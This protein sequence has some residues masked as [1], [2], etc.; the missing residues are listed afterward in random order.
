MKGQTIFSRAMNGECRP[1]HCSVLTLG[2]D[3]E[4]V[5]VGQR[6]AVA[7]V[8]AGLLLA[9]PGLQLAALAAPGPAAVALELAAQVDAGA[10]VQAGP[11]QALVQVPFAARAREP[12]PAQALEPVHQVAAQLGAG[13]AAGRAPFGRAL[14]HVL[15]AVRAAEAARARALEPGPPVGAGA[16]VAAGPGR[17]VVHQVLAL[18]PVVAG[19]ALAVVAVLLK[20]RLELGSPP[21]RSSDA[22]L[23]FD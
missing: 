19:R 13:R 20:C 1:A 9:G 6:D 4:V 15:L 14:V 16:V 11:G 21:T 23:G 5:V 7:A 22:H 12:G 18:G 10:V 8:Q 3:A 17:A 2:A